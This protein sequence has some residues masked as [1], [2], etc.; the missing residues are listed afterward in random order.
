MD[1]DAL[2]DAWESFGAALREVPEQ[3]ASRA[4]LG[5]LMQSV[6]LSSFG[7][8][9]QL[10]AMQY[11]QAHISAPHKTGDYRGLQGG[12]FGFGITI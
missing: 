1:D 5:R 2:A 3:R 4:M 12:I 10:D 6:A 8:K 9:G 11:Q 7:A